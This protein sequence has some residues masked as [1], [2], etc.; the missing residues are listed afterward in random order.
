MTARGGRAAAP[1]LILVEGLPGAGKSTLAQRVTLAL[2]RQGRP[3]RWWYEEQRGHPL[4]P[5]RG[6]AGLRRVVDDLFSGRHARV[7]AAVLARWEALAA[8]ITAD[9]SGATVVL[10]G[11]LFGHLTWSLFPADVPREEIAAYV[12]AAGQRLEGVPLL[13]LRLRQPDAGAAVARVWRRRGAAAGAAIRRATDNPYARRRG[14]TG[15]AGAA[16]YWTAFDALVDDL[17]ARLDLPRLALQT[18]PPTWSGATTR[19]L[20]ALGLPAR[21]PPAPPAP[22]LARL[23]GAY[24]RLAPPR[25]PPAGAGSASTGG[26]STWTAS[27]TSGL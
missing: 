8:A 25:T 5:F 1:R 14:L 13:L 20:R 10:D 27:P 22:A 7:V 11:M 21:R 16:A 26:R 2:Q 9:A 15:R 23:A 17:F 19:A 12:L 4:H 24:A 6:P 3:V 18:G